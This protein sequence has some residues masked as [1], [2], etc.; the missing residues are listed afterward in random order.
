[1]KLFRELR[2]P[3]CGLFLFGTLLLFVGCKE[4]ENKNDTQEEERYKITFPERI[5][6]IHIYCDLASLDS[7]YASWSENKYITV[8][9][10]YG[11][12]KWEKVKMRLRGDSSREYPKKSLKLL[13]GGTELFIGGRRKLNLNAEYKDKSFFKQWLCSELMKASGQECYS[14]EHIKVF[15]NDAF[16]GVYLQVENMDHDFMVKNNLDPNSNLYKATK[17]G[18]SLSVFEDLSKKWEKKSNERGSWNDLELLIYK[19]NNTS[20]KDFLAFLKSDFEYDKLI[21]L[22]ALNMYLANGSTYYH[23]YYMYHDLYK[24]G[25]WQ[26]L[27]WDMD[28]TLSYYAWMPFE[29]NRT[30]SNWESDNMLIERALINDTVLADIEKRLVVLSET[31]FNPDN[32]NPILDQMEHVLKDAVAMDKTDNVGSVEAWKKEIEK[33]R[34]FFTKQCDHLLGQIRSNPRGFMTHRI[35]GIV[36]KDAKIEWEKSRSPIGKKITYTL[37]VSQD[38]L[39]E[40]ESTKVYEGIEETYFELKGLSEGTYFWQVEATDGQNKTLACNSKNILNVKRYSVLPARVENSITLKESESPYY[41]GKRVD[42]EKDLTIEPG[43]KI[44]IADGGVISCN[45]AKVTMVGTKEKPIELLPAEKAWDHIYM[46]NCKQPC[47]FKYVL[48]YEGILNSKYSDLSISNC[49]FKVEKKDMDQNGRRAGMIWIEGGK[50]NFDRNKLISNG[51]GEGMN[52]HKAQT[53]ITNSFFDNAPDAIELINVDNASVAYNYVLNSPDDAIDLNG[54]NGVVIEH[55]FLKNNKDKGI[56][57]GTEQYGSSHNIVV[58]YNL[59]VDNEL[60]ICVKDDSDA[61]GTNNTL[62]GNNIGV[63][64]Y[65]KNSALKKG[66]RMKL[67]K[68]IIVDSNTPQR[69]DE[70]S[71]LVI[72]NSVSN[73]KSLSGSGNKEQPVQ[74]VN[75]SED[76]YYLIENK[77]KIGAFLNSIPMVVI[78][79]VWIADSLKNRLRI[80]LKNSMPFDV[81]LSLWKIKSGDDAFTFPVG[82]VLLANGKLTIAES[83]KRNGP[84]SENKLF[85]EK[86]PFNGITDSCQLINSGNHVIS[87]YK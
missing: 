27:P 1:M 75:A 22:M 54:C 51:Q 6:D 38:F 53:Q 19:I 78:Q 72:N 49:T 23:N 58:N 71:S 26:L 80:K 16:Y 61:S 37:R 63:R 81:D 62:V 8:S 65:R 14:T 40:S 79:E 68:M 15:I 5:E 50:L 84:N 25:K 12:K 67:D 77:D 64:S 57:I 48:L 44:Y 4:P 55:N 39:F 7:I 28:K 35:K 31:T 41:V 70:F 18:A 76:N 60:G 42:F 20:N 2:M 45:N 30:S 86:F 82:T 17:D 46:M 13:F 24:T 74:F 73:N 66:G 83:K 87:T 21:N 10:Q 34:R 59:I 47:T 29:Y 3:L 33:D 56:S 32:I 85:I 69:Y 36:D 9:V 52:I 43:V 11:G